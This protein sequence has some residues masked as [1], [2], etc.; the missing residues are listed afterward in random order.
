MRFCFVKVCLSLCLLLSLAACGGA[1][2]ATP[3]ATLPTSTPVRATPTPEFVSAAR[4][5]QVACPFVLPEGYTQGENVECGYLV[6]PEDR[7]RLPS[8]AVRLAVGIFHPKGGAATPDPVLYLSGGPG[9]SVLELVR[10]QFE[11]FFAPIMEGAR[12]DLIVF[13]Q[14]GV[15]RSRPP[16]D[17]PNVDALALEMLDRDLEERPASDQEMFDLMTEAYLDCAA[18]LRQVAD[19]TMYNTAASAA[20]VNDLCLALGYEQ[21]NL[22]GGSYGTRLALGVM[23]DY[24]EVLRSVVLDSVYPPDVDLYVEAPSNFSRALNKLFEDCAANPVCSD[25]YPDLRMVFFDTVAHLNESPVTTTITNTLTGQGY[26]SVT[27]GNTLLG[28]VFQVLYETEFKYLLPQF[29]Y[30]VSQ[31][32]WTAIDAIRGALLAQASVSSR[33]TMFSVQC[34]EEI[35][36]SSLA[37][38]ESVLAQY[39]ELAG[40]YEYATLGK[41]T[42][43]VCEGWGAGEADSIENEPVVSDVPTLLM[44]G[45]F[46]PVTPPAWARHAA[47]TLVNGYFF[48]YPGVGHG[49][50]AEGC[51]REMMLA[52][53]DSPTTVPDDAC[54]AGMGE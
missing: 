14:R 7:S 48:E 44:A 3:P 29:I 54:N 28:F 1:T 46:D 43:R 2:T 39:P 26:P 13:D 30:D 47:E 49:A 5:E 32:D 41:L 18:D 31:N 42:Y 15:G 34:H 53:L 36:F 35:A 4:F 16:L 23:R 51:G 17:C 38:Y 45:E 37:E 19:L 8:R 10:Y 50:S 9:A 33:G 40:L 25:A 52:F 11:G 27:T 22:W 6:V 12:R 20:D 21:V 24:P